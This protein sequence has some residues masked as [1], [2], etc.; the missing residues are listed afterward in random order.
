MDSI[1]GQTFDDFEFLIIDDGSTEPVADIIEAYHD[2][3]VMFIRQR[4]M[5][6][7]RSLNRAIDLALG[8]YVAR[9]DS[10]DISDL[11]RL[12][13]QFTEVTQNPRLDMVGTFFDIIDENDSLIRSRELIVDPLYRLWRLQFHNNYAH[14]AMLMKKAAVQSIGKY[15]PSLKFAQDYDLWRRLSKKDNTLIIP[16]YLYKYRLIENSAQAS[17]KNYDDQLEAAITI[18]NNNLRS[19]MVSLTDEELIQVRSVYWNFQEPSVS[20]A[21]LRLVPGLF[22]GFCER[23][24]IDKDQ[25]LN[26]WSVIEKDIAKRLDCDTYTNE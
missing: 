4:N 20:S 24:G 22:E 1:L 21:G 5:G 14:G 3:R 2:C 15:D 12:E 23:Y 11:K 13:K 26:L 25:R 9:M 17:V 7:T 16:E 8:D 10:D 18:S 6:L 19:S